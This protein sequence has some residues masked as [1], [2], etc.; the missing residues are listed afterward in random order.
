VRTARVQL[1]SR[2]I[3][4]HI[5]HPAGA[6]AAVRNAIMQAKTSEDYYDDLAWLYGGTGLTGNTQ[7]Q[8]AAGGG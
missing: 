3:G 7:A 5:Y 6:H 4:D 2:A 1:Q 8:A